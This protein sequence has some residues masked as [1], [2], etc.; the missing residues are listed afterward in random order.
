MT[1]QVQLTHRVASALKARQASPL[2][3]CHSYSSGAV[4]QQQRAD[5]QPDCVCI[6]ATI[7]LR[8]RIKD[9][10][11]ETEQI[12]MERGPTYYIMRESIATN[13]TTN[14]LP[15]ASQEP[16]AQL[17]IAQSLAFVQEFS[18]PFVSEM[19]WV[20]EELDAE[21]ARRK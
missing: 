16:A 1:W 8:N 12:V 3:S 4:F 5:A 7:R 9:G 2:R 15:S 11:Y 13:S 17:V 10:T 18:R 6:L 14:A 21:R 19:G 20:R